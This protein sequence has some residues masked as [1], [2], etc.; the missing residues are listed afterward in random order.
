M[1]TNETNEAMGKSAN[2]GNGKRDSGKAYKSASSGWKAHLLDNAGTYFSYLWKMP[3]TPK[4]WLLLAGNTFGDYSFKQQKARWENMGNGFDDMDGLA[5]GKGSGQLI[6]AWIQAQREVSLSA[7]MARLEAIVVALDEISTTPHEKALTRF[8]ASKAA[9]AMEGYTS[10]LQEPE[11]RYQRY[12]KQVKV[13][14]AAMPLKSYRGIS[15]RNVYLGKL[16]HPESVF[17]ACQRFLDAATVEKDAKA[18][19]RFL[20]KWKKQTPEKPED[21]YSQLLA[22]TH[23]QD[24]PDVMGEVFDGWFE[25]Y[26][27]FMLARVEERERLINRG[28]DLI[29]GRWLLKKLPFVGHKSAS[30]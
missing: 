12:Q 20:S 3:K 8:V 11:A 5:L 21:F 1:T 16:F 27:E 24:D 19:Q 17:T 28:M 14:L 29:D 18:L 6:G 10:K 4:G 13:L 9:L 25:D 23:R 7:H 2:R 30:S 26:R 22:M 15:Q